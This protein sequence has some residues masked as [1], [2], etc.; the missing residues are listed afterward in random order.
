[1][2]RTG[3]LIQR[4]ADTDNILLAFH[5]AFR[6]KGK[7]AGALKFQRHLEENVSNLRSEILAGEVTVGNYEYFFI[8][9]PKKRLI[10]AASFRERVLHHAIMNVCHDV[11]ERNLIETT[12]ATR[13]GKGIYKAIDRAKMAM[14]KY[15]YVA[16]FDFR[17]YFDSISHRILSEKLQRLFKDKTLL[18]IFD[19]IIRSYSKSDGG[20]I[21]IGNLT[22]QYF[23]NYY[24]SAMDHWIKE[25]LHV[26]EYLRYM[27]DFL[28]FADS[29]AEID[30][31][32]KSIGEYAAKKLSLS[33]KPVIVSASAEGIDFLG[34]RVCPDKILLTQRGKKRFVRKNRL[35]GHLV[36]TG[37][38]SQ[39]EYYEHIT[40]LLSYVQKAYTKGLRLS[41]FGGNDNG[42]EPRVARWRL[43]QQRK[44][45]PRCESQQQHPRQPQQQ[46]RLPPG[47]PLA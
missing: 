45:L 31:F 26:P 37:V 30:R 23:A 27:D 34:Y 11:F 28:V 18:R 46:Q 38:W 42:L 17:K 25:R 21:P 35:Y 33:L 8:E 43:E 3:N 14:K 10:C 15:R 22:S 7:A 29:R 24:L 5:K 41:V 36:E 1:M 9:D 13:P 20:G 2:K 47:V 19:T 32:K 12:Y 40:P 16:K 4:I 6:G 44:E 39:K